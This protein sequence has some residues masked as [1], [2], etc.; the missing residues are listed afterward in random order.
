MIDLQPVSIALDGWRLR[1]AALLVLLALFA[2]SGGCE[3]ATI[4]PP[5]GA[6]GPADAGP[7]A[8]GVEPVSYFAAEVAPLLYAECR[9]CHGP[10][11]GDL[12]F[13]E[14][15]RYYESVRAGTTRAGDPLLVPGEPD[16]S[17]LVS[18]VEGGSHTGGPYEA[19]SRDKVRAWIAYEGGAPVEAVD[20]GPPEVLDPPHSAPQRVLVGTNRIPLDTGT[21]ALAGAFFTFEAARNG[22]DLILTDVRLEAGAQ[23]VSVTEPRLYVWQP[24]AMEGTRDAN[25]NRFM[26]SNFQVSAGGSMP[27]AGREVFV[28]F[29]VDGELSVEF[30]TVQHVD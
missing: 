21:V 7:P 12:F 4:T 9:G 16:L 18:Y 2:L 26:Q 3:L 28:D 11:D 29:P 8:G 1:P 27:L 30:T 15:D 22:A 13:L 19:G 10:D 6:F 24:G 23:G 20:A 5:V 25:T 17:P 14:P